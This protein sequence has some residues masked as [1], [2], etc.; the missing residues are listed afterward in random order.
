MTQVETQVQ[1]G[2]GEGE[3]QAQ[4]QAV[5]AITPEAEAKPEKVKRGS[6]VYAVAEVDELPPKNQ[7]GGLNTRDLKT[8]YMP[9]LIEVAQGAG[10]WFQVARYTSTTG[11]RSAAKSVGKAIADGLIPVQGGT[12]EL[13]SRRNVQQVNED[14]SPGEIVPSILYAKFVVAE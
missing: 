6:P 12:F 7:T 13:D 2:Q 5:P 8:I 3:A 9:L 14:G 4:P 10:H 11:A 1:E